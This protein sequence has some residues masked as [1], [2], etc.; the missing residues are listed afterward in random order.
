MNHQQESALSS[1]RLA[2]DDARHEI[3]HVHQWLATLFRAI[4]RCREDSDECYHL[5]DMGLYLAERSAGV[6]TGDLD[7]L[8]AELAKLREAVA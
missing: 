2:A 6:S 7:H 8:K 4:Q 1:A 5:A 3:Q